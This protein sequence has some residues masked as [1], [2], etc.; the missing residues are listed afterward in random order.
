MG[1]EKQVPAGNGARQPGSS[2]AG[3]KIAVTGKGGSGKTMLTA[4]MTGLLAREGGRRI[5]AIDADSAVN[6]P[7][8]LGMDANRTVAQIRRWIIEDPAARSEIEDRNIREVM[9]EALES[10]DGFSLLVMGRPEG[11]GC[12]CA[13]ND[14]LKYGI[15]RLSKQFDVTLIDC[16]AGPEQ[17][18]RRVVNGVDSLIIVTDA[19]V[20]G[21]RVAGSIMEVVS[22][23]AELKPAET[24]LV[25]NRFRGDDRMI[26]ERANEWDVEILGRIPEDDNVTEYDAAGRPITDL[27]EGSPSVVAVAQILKKISALASPI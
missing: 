6:L 21:A 5:L 24:G 10:G 17:V 14:L 12:Y 13:I 4:V 16:E 15:E 9:E 7:Y 25:I 19:S 26:A 8:A 22:G 3:R 11:P 20:R 2:P 23:D 1:Q 27:P 18:N